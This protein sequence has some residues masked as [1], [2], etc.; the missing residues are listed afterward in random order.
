MVLATIFP[1]HQGIVAD[2]M[3]GPILPLAKAAL[4]VQAVVATP[5]VRAILAHEPLL[6]GD[7]CELCDVLHLLASLAS[8]SHLILTVAILSDTSSAFRGQ[9]EVLGL[10]VYQHLLNELVLG[11]FLLAHPIAGKEGRV[12]LGLSYPGACLA[13]EGFR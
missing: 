8:V 1:I 10:P 7:R 5:Y 4:W 12:C 6:H 11:H 13:V 2:G 9:H 3:R